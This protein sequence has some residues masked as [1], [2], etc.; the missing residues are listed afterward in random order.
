MI[1]AVVGGRLQGVEAVYLSR[2]AGFQTLVIDKEP[3]VPASGLCDHFMVYEFRSGNPLPEIKV[4]LILPTI[5]NDAALSLIHT[6]SKQAGIPMAFDFNAYAVS[7]SKKK[8]NDLFKDLNLPI[9]GIW[10][11]CSFPV[12]VKPDKAGGSRGVVILQD[13][14]TVDDWISYQGTRPYVIQEFVRGPSVSIEVLGSPGNHQALQ[15]TDL[16][17]DGK[18]DCNRVEAPS[19]LRPNQIREFEHMALDLAKSLNLTGIMDLEAIVDGNELKLLEIDARLPSQTPMAVFW[20][21][22]V[23]MVKMLAQMITTGDDFADTGLLSQGKPVLIEHIKV[24]GSTVEY[25]GEH[26]ISQDGPLFLKK[27]FFGTDEAITS[28]REGKFFWVATMIFKG[29][30]REEIQARRT[31]CYGEIMNHAPNIAGDICI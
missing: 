20:S 21:T 30:T 6:W 15:V 9:P 14:K 29:K 13:E 17:M 16:G 2:K 31:R 22:G 5:E 10:P 24:T 19:R 11:N 7:S 3:R 12:A 28:H 4:D 26:I 1:I 25:S 8:S 27:D 23:N 18:Y